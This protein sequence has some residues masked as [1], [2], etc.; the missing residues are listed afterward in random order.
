MKSFVIIGL[1]RFG[2]ALSKELSRIGHEVLAIDY[3]PALISEVADYVTHAVEADAKN[4]MALKEIGLSNFDV[5]VISIGSD[6]EASIIATLTC[7]ELG[8]KTI[9][10]KATSESHGKVL[11]KIGASKIIFPERDM[12]TRLAHNLTP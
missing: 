3:D 9:I 6:L 11:S 2:M 10:A 8:I 7:K 12:G 1:G 4:E 5:A